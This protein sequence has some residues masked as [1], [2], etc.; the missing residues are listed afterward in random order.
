MR[1]YSLISS[2]SRGVYITLDPDVENYITVTGET[3][4][5]FINLLNTL[6]IYLK[7][8]GLYSKLQMWH[9]YFGNASRAKY[10]FLNPVDSDSAFR[11]TYPAGSS[12]IDNNGFSGNFSQFADTHFSP[13]SIQNINSNGLTL[14]CASNNSPGDDTIE[15]GAFNSATQLSTLVVKADNIAYRVGTALNNV[16]SVAKR[17]GVNDSRGIFTGSKTTSSVHKLFIDGI[18]TDTGTGGGSLPTVPLF[19]MA[20][21]LGGSTYGQSKQR[22]L[23]TMAHEGLTDAEV[24]LLHIGLDDFEFGLGRKTW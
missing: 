11:L 2:M 20:L 13:S 6:V 18:L 21:N 14:V 22:L 24:S 15:F 1:Y 16:G 23:H 17:D 4:T 10:N 3:N 7:T 8:N 19:V 9:I 5:V 12:G